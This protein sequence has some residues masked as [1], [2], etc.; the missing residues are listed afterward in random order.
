MIR[1]N[2]EQLEDGLYLVEYYKVE[3]EPI[4]EIYVVSFELTHG[5][6]IDYIHIENI[7]SLS[8]D[9]IGRAYEYFELIENDVINSI[10]NK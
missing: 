6:E 10:K 9:G 2:I 1:Y 7:D 4:K 5:N 8:D 3:T